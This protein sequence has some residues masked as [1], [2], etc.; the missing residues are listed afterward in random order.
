M[1][2]ERA[3]AGGE[4]SA[5]WCIAGVETINFPTAPEVLGDQEARKGQGA[6][7][8]RADAM[9]AI[10]PYEFARRLHARRGRSCYDP[11]YRARSAILRL[12][13]PLMRTTLPL[14]IVLILVSAAGQ[15]QPP[16]APPAPGA[17]GNADNVPYIGKSDP[18]G[19][20]VR[21]A[22]AT[23][24][25]SNY[26]EEKVAPYT[27]PDPLVLASGERVA[28]ADDWWQRRRPEILK[29]FETEV[30]GR[31]PATAPRV[32]W[33]VV[34]SGTSYRDGLGT[35]RRVVGRMGDAADGPAMHLT[36]YSPARA[37]APTPLLLALSFNFGGQ[38]G[39]AAKGK[40]PPPPAKSGQA[41]PFG[42]I[43][44]VL[45]RGWTYAALSYTDIQPDRPGQW[46]QGVIGL[47]LRPGQSQPAPDEWGTISA[48]AWGL[49]R[50]I[51]YFETDKSVHPRQIAI[52][53]VSR[54]GKTVLWAAAQDQR[55][56]AVFSV[57][58]GEMGAS[59]IRRDWGET[60]DDMAQNFGYQFAGNLQ[61]YVA[62]G[63]TC[64]LISTCSLPC[65]LRGPCMSTVASPTS[66][67]IRTASFSR[68]SPRDRSIGCWAS[69]ILASRHCRRST[70]HSRRGAWP[71]ITTAA[72]TPRSPP[73]GRRSWSLPSGT[74][75]PRDPRHSGGRVAKKFGR[76]WG[77][78]TL[79]SSARHTAGPSGLNRSAAH[80]G[81]VF[82]P[83]LD[84]PA[85]AH[86]PDGRGGV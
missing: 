39:G 36:V 15:A 60:L 22:K 35:L 86:W 63:T 6:S 66:G 37:A 28:T 44:E 34:E 9:V 85:V 42:A 21:L 7:N 12:G 18:Q 46:Q 79:P 64:P 14:A 49:A 68:W 65:V 81:S 45:G 33:E 26:S 82:R 2:A 52:T 84:K 27:L 57:V 47:A 78:S 17:R 16:A 5:L 58:P 59:L 40:T 31:V 20:P 48:W 55:V 76:T 10:E 1:R 19:N 29:T 13:A 77:A 30:Y 54:L 69:R 83:L 51:D 80:R 50:A 4:V 24:H 72:A 38:R 71:S 11:P 67:A 74:F 43:G 62:V 61:K 25:V 75:A 41:P 8:G 53:G 73:T 23:G 3:A 32:T 70:S 56:A